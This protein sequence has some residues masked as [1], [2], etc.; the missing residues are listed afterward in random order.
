M[1]LQGV[2]DKIVVKVLIEKEKVTKAGII[3]TQDAAQNQEPQVAGIVMSFGDKVP[4]DLNAGDI[5]LFNRRAGMDIIL[6]DIIYKVMKA[7]EVYGR[8]LDENKENDKSK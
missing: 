8:L 7:E 6:D 2:M 4:F 1:Y 3:L 5:L